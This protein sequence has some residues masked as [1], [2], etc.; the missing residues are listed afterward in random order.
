MANT[1]V[2]KFFSLCPM[3]EIARKW[4]K[5]KWKLKGSVSVSAMPGALFLFKFAVEEDV[6]LVLFGYSSHGRNNL[7]LCRWKAGFDLAANL[8][9]IAPVWVRLPVP[10]LNTRMSPS[11]NELGIPLVILLVLMRLPEPNHAWSMLIYVFKLL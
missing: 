10:P 8:Q 7:S 1:L 2:G 5:D 3:M 9:K 4:V 11:L 6:T